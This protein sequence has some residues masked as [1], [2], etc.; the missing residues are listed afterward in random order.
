MAFVIVS[1]TPFLLI[2]VSS[3]NEIIWLTKSW[4]LKAVPTPTT[5]FEPAVTVIV[6]VPFE[7]ASKNFVSKIYSIAII[8]PVHY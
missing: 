1:I 3:I 7:G 4:V 5:V 8:Y 2:P 6:P